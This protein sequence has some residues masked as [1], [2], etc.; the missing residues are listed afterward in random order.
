M[1]GDTGS[2]FDAL[3]VERVENDQC[4]GQVDG[5]DS[6]GIADTRAA[7]D[8]HVVVRRLHL[9]DQ[10]VEKRAATKAAIKAVP[11]EAVYPRAV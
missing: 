3:V 7:V 6:R 5:A 9:R 4:F 11:V 8:E 1:R 2:P 10:L